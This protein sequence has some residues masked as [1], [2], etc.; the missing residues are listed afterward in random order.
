[1]VSRASSGYQSSLCYSGLLY[2]S[3]IFVK[4]AM[5]ETER[6]VDVKLD[7]LGRLLI[8]AGIR[9]KLGLSSSSRLVLRLRDGRLE[10]R[11]RAGTVARAQE[12]VR[13]HID[14]KARLVDELISQRRK[15]A[16]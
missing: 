12:L 7:K 14:A 3:A 11:T 1:M 5:S 6:E 8:P 4:I 15:E 10:L 16:Q 2:K 9:K 13:K